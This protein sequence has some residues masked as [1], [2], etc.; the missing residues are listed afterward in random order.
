MP[1]DSGKLKQGNFMQALE[2]IGAE[3]ERLMK[4]RDLPPEVKAGLERIVALGKN[5]SSEV[6][7]IA[8]NLHEPGR[9]ADLAASNLEL[10]LDEAQGLLELLDPLYLDGVVATV[11]AGT[12]PGS[13]GYA[14]FQAA[15][16][17]HFQR[18]LVSPTP[19]IG[20]DAALLLLEALRPGRLSPSEIRSSFQ[21][22][23]DIEGATGTFSVVDDRVVRRTDLVRIDRRRL[24]PVFF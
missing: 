1:D 22:L 12:G 7:V 9:L 23:R 21:G 17:L 11:P 13:P 4:R 18:T 3:A 16:E 19:A 6:M 8:A 10:K 15:Y 5:I 20:Y 14:R 2:S 24:V